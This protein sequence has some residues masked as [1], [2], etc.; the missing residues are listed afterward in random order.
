MRRN[1][2]PSLPQG[3]HH[4]R[5]GH[6]VKFV[7]LLEKARILE[8]DPPTP[9]GETKSTHAQSKNWSNLCTYTPNP[10]QIITYFYLPSSR[11]NEFLA[12]LS[13]SFKFQCIFHH[14]KTTYLIN[15]RFYALGPAS[16]LKTG[17]FCFLQRPPMFFETLVL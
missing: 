5:S 8:R 17:N 11:I 16:G 1:F 14:A 4:S 2:K 10:N 9:Y 6:F 7:I 15:E 3:G 12:F 13:L